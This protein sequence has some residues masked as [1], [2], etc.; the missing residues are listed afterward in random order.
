MSLSAII[1]WSQSE[2]DDDVDNVDDDD[3]SIGDGVGG[4]VFKW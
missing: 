4:A 2:K 3:F 1:I